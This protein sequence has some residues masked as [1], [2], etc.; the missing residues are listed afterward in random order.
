MHSDGGPRPGLLIVFEGIDG[1]G[2]STQVRLL[3]EALRARGCTV[4][5][6]FEPTNGP[7]GRRIRELF[8]SRSSLSRTEELALFMA[9]RRQ[10]VAEVIAPALA[11]GQVVISDRY[12][13]STAAYQGA[14]GLDPEEIIAANE[15]FAPVPDCV[16]LLEAPIAVGRH[17][18]ESI[19]GEVLNDF[20]QET[21]LRQVAAVFAAIRRT[22]IK[23]V[24]ATGS[25]EE[26]HRAALGHVL[27]LLGGGR[28]CMAGGHGK[29][30]VKACYD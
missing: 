20:E 29:E 15:A 3:A 21:T 11:A 28:R 19:R 30:E 23:R 1:T 4:V 13:L 16:L 18:I 25:I 26:V 27:P 14:A 10:H 6:T 12:Y 5:T 8:S 24:D 2:K 7:H 22:Y 17:R 9:D